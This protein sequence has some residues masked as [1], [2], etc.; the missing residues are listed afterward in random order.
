[1]RGVP[2]VVLG[3]D[4]DMHLFVGVDPRRLESG[5]PTGNASSFFDKAG[6]SLKPTDGIVVR[7]RSARLFPSG[8]EFHAFV[9]PARLAEYLLNYETIHA[10]TYGGGG[11]YSGLS[12]GTKGG[13]DAGATGGDIAVLVG[14]SVRRG[15]R[16]VRKKM[17]EALE[18]GNRNALRRGKITPQE[19]QEL[20]R[21]MDENGRLGEEF[22]LNYE[23][24]TLRRGAR[25]DLAERVRWISQQSVAEGYDILS[26]E[27]D[28]T[29]KWIEVKSTSGSAR[30][31]EMSDYEW[32][33]CCSAG[34]K[35]Y[36]YRV[37][38]VRTAAPLIEKVRDPRRLEAD[39]L[40]V[41]SAHG[42]KVTLR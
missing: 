33:T 4:P 29:E 22:V 15:P 35:Y 17:V 42:W 1:L 18:T 31:F 8:I 3:F 21:Y 36:I 12:S 16:R 11:L 32:R 26:Y 28:G 39:G 25:P 2:D 24:R 41:K 5:G 27:P 9:T 19:F 7:Q 6:L 38:A 37:T 23:R 13:L 34:A 10:G 20:R 14:P 30:T 40:I